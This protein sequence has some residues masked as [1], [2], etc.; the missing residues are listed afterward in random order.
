MS[1]ININNKK[2]IYMIGNAHLDPVWLWRYMEG[3]A[4]IKATFRSA[5]DRIN[6][7]DDFIFTSA[8]AA[9][10]EWV[11]ENE[12]EMFEEIQE[13][14]KNN[15]WNIAGGMWIQPDCNIPNGESF[16]RHLLI[17]QRY[18][19][20]KFGKIAKTGYNVDSFGHNASLPQ[21]LNKSGIDSYVYMRPDDSEKKYRGYANLFRWQS[22]DGSEVLTYRILG[23][24]CMGLGGG[25]FELYENKAKNDNEDKML[26]Y[27]VG[28][29]GGGPTVRMIEEIEKR[30]KENKDF[31]YI[32]AGPEEYFENIKKQNYN[33]PVLKGDLQHHASGCYSANSMIKALNR[34]A[35]NRLLTAEKYNILAK[36]LLGYKYDNNKLNYAWKNILFNQ[37]HDIMGG[38][39]IKE[40]YDDARETFGESLAIGS[41]TI[42]AAI[43]KISWNIDTAKTVKYLSKDMDWG[44]WEQANL[45]TPIVI[46]N[47]LSWNI[48]VPVT[49]NNNRISRVEGADGN[50]TPVQVVRA[51]QTNGWDGS[52][53]SLF[54]AEVPAMGYAVYWA[55][56]NGE[57]IQK[58]NN[59]SIGYYH[60]ANNYVDV[61]FDENT[62]N[63]KS[64]FGVHEDDID[65]I[66]DY[67]AKT[68]VVNDEKQDTWSH[69]VFTFDKEVGEF[70]S[71]TFEIIERGDVKI[72]LRVTQKYNTSEI[73]Q[74]YTLYSHSKNL[75]V[76]VRVI[77]NEKLKIFKLCFKLNTDKKTK[78]IYEI[79]YGYIEKESNGEEEPAQNFACV[80]DGD[81]GLA[82][83]NKGKYSY[84]VKDNEIRFIAARSCVYAD[85]YGVH[86][87]M[88][89]GRYEYQD[90]GV[91]YFKYVLKGYSGSFKEN[92]ADIVKAG[93]EL[94]TPSYSIAETYHQ[95]NLPQK[96]T[97]VE[98]KNEN[99]I[100]TAAK[101]A[102]DNDGVV[103]RF[104]ETSG[105][106][107]QSE[108]DVK[109]LNINIK[110]DF[111][112]FEIKTVKIK[113]GICK[114]VD[115]L[116]L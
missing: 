5:L 42:N 86:S 91:M 97:G 61:W 93:L 96:F 109:F 108:I 45:G 22:P 59:M 111:K 7:F 68:V 103:L 31:E 79:P 30:K 32:Y 105:K 47:P 27:G 65:I 110:L 24:Y 85:H 38:C 20:E 76:D 36:E 44:L 17:S 69:G 25:D 37:F 112:A 10:Y 106:D 70:G 35:E 71:P 39:S 80:E 81:I 99:I 4:E 51:S 52:F 113:D 90:Q 115:L 12:P 92:A 64:F 74:D 6:Q 15:K 87:G 1:D 56:F 53:N 43:Q 54:C 102:E 28:N 101:N 34:E 50:P 11:E 48:K 100:L 21:I 58:D 14:V 94:N 75:E 41:K 88:R 23:A 55:Y 46:F 104:L 29:H 62:G 9:Y 40:A 8:C 66:K 73:R 13:A 18:F 89:D 82:V 57:K 107:T 72:T 33:I 77:N 78:A 19:K 95:G 16:A 26:F 83:I 84:S 116:E 2:K 49:I 114:E 67:A 3:F 98:I 60:L 63:I